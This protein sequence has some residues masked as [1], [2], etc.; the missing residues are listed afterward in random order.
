[1]LEVIFLCGFSGLAGFIDSIVGGGGL[2]QLPALFIFLPQIAVPT[3]F[4]TSKLAAIAGTSIAVVQYTRHVKISWRATLPSAI[5][6]FIFSFLGARIVSLINPAMLRPAILVLLIAVA[7]YTFVKKDFG[8]LHAPKLEAAMQLWVGIAIGAII[9]FYDGFF[10]PGTGSF[11]TFAFIGL[12]GF[13]FL[14]AAAS[15]RVVNFATNLSA[16]LYFAAT[17]NILY[18]VALPMAVCNIT[19]SLIGSRMALTKGSQFIRVLFLVVVSA[20]ILKFAYDLLKP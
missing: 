1:M 4:G 7:I 16:M 18:Q 10:G 15:A 19:G 8:N 17:G 2:I 6:A 12:F 3:I 20:L 9:G 14:N 11:L 5:A 13:D